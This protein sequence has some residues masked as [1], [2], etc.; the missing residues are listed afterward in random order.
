MKMTDGKPVEHGYMSILNKC[1][2]KITNNSF[3]SEF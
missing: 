2:Y 3:N 1:L